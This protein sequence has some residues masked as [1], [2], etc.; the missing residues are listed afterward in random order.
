MTRILRRHGSHREDDGAI[1]WNTLLLLLCR[2]HEH[3]TASR[4]TNPE[5]LHTGSGKKRFQYCLNSD[6]FIFYVRAIQGRNQG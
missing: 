2:D 3:E 4:L 1:D 5:W 6:G